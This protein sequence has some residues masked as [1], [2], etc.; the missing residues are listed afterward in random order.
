[1]TFVWPPFLITCLNIIGVF[2]PFND[3]GEREE[4]VT[5][6][7]TTLLTMAVILMIITDQMPKSS[8]TPLLG[9]CRLTAL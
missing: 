8:I 7:L 5:M 3:G 4:K 1:M 6:G 9:S 2:A